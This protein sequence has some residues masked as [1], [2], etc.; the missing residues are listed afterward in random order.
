M[1]TSPALDLSHVDAGIRVQDDLFG[2]VNGAWL[3]THEIPADRSTDGAFYAL[4][5]AAEETVRTIVEECAADADATGDTA[6]IGA[7]YASFMDTDGIAAAGLAP[8]PTS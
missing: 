3:E 8:W 6:R 1:T 4:R 5:D 2:H 7:L